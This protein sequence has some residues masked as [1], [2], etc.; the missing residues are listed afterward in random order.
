MIRRRARRP[1]PIGP[2]GSCCSLTSLAPP[3]STILS[4][5]GTQPGCADNSISRR[6]QL[7]KKLDDSSRLDFRSEVF[8]ADAGWI[9]KSPTIPMAEQEV[10]KFLHERA[11]L[12]RRMRGGREHRDT[13]I[14]AVRA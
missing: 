14:E 3:L 7:T 4:T 6:P 13:H 11:R 1:L 12:I 9:R 8:L 2:G 5:G 10:V